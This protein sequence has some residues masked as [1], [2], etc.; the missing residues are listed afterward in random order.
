LLTS[1]TIL[2]ASEISYRRRDGK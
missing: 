1:N 2:E